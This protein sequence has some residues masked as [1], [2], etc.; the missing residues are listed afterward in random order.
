MHQY[1]EILVKKKEMKLAA[2]LNYII[3]QTYQ[4]NQIREGIIE[5]IARE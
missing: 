5:I 2:R 3:F 1:T 4:F